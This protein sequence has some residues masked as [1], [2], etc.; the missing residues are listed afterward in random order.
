MYQIHVLFLVIINIL[1]SISGCT[2]FKGRDLCL[3][4]FDMEENEDSIEHHVNEDHQIVVSNNNEEND[5][6][7]MFFKAML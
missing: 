7:G 6:T 2:N 5:N 3:I 1:H 4:L